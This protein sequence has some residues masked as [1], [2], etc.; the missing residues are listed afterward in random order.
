MT[1]RAQNEFDEVAVCIIPAMKGVLDS[2][3][4]DLLLHLFLEF[5]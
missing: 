2:I 3:C 1:N 4:S 5:Q